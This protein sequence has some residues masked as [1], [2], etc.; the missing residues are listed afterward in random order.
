MSL[1]AVQQ[2]ASVKKRCGRVI[3]DAIALCNKAV[4]VFERCASNMQELRNVVC[5]RVLKRERT[6]RLR[7]L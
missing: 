7:A 5:V 1:I 3:K 2:L 6:R 4:R